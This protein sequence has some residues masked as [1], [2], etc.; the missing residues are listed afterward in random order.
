MQPAI[1]VLLPIYKPNLAYLRQAIASMLQ[2]TWSDFELILIEARPD[3]AT[4][5]LLD[6]FNDPRIRNHRYDGDP[7]IIHQ[8][9]EGLL[10]AKA[11]LIARMDGDD[12]S[13]PERLK[14]QFYFLSAHPE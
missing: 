5:T 1:S 12:W 9:N 10:A 8:L 7:S 13:Y 2:Q 14:R 3:G 6:E 11:N 4:Q